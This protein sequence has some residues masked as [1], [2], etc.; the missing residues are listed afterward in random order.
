MQIMIL[1]STIRNAISRAA[2][3]QK[4]DS[5]KSLGPI[6]VMLRFLISVSKAKRMHDEVGG[7][8]FWVGAQLSEQ[9]IKEIDQMSQRA[10]EVNLLGY[11]T[12]LDHDDALAQ[13]FKAKP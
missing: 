8:A 3:E 4:R 5:V 11:Q 7:S 9:E 6:C 12:C 10:D 13:A 2:Y 1:D